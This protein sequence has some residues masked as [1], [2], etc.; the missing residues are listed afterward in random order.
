MNPVSQHL[1]IHRLAVDEKLNAKQIVGADLKCPDFADFE[2]P[3]WASGQKISQHQVE[4]KSAWR[5]AV[6][7]L[8][9][10]LAR[11]P[12]GSAPQSASGRD[13]DRV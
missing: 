6:L 7:R 1:L 10:V 12:S 11:G 9:L 5:G 3:L 2:C 13:V 8:L 4:V